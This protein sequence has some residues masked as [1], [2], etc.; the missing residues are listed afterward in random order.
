VVKELDSKGD[1]AKMSLRE[2]EEEHSLEM[3]LP[4]IYTILA[5]CVSVFDF[6][7]VG[8]FLP[9]HLLYQLWLAPRMQRKRKSTVDFSHLIWPTKKTSSLFQVISAIGIIGLRTRLIQGVSISVYILQ[10]RQPSLDRVY[11]KGDLLLSAYLQSN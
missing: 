10:Q 6:L 11:A 8:T 7:T 1:F 3:H 9:S 5:K 2:D 4:Y